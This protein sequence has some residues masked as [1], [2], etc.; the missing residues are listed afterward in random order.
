LLPLT[1]DFGQRQRFYL[2]FEGV[3]MR[4]DIMEALTTRRSIRKYWNKPLSVGVLEELLE[5]ARYYPSGLNLQ[6]LKFMPV[7]EGEDVT[8]VT[9]NLRWAGYLPGY[10]IGV[11]ERPVSYILMFG[12][13]QIGNQFDFAAGSAVNQLLLA[14]HGMG[15]GG[16]CLAIHKKAQILEHFQLDAERFEALYAIAI[17]YAKHG[18]T[19]TDLTTDCKYTLDENGDFVVPKRTVSELTIKK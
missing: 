5:V 1:H 18:A 12:D 19:T 16:C 7:T 9:E 13:R 2:A 3:E 10:E 6:P 14:V 8:F 4:M 17:G 11:D 15:L